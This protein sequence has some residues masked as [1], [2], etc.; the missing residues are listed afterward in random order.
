MSV[1]VAIVGSGIAGLSAAHHLLE[2]AE[3]SLFEADDHFG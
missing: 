2:H 3:V 1:R